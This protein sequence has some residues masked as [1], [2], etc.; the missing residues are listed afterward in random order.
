MAKSNKFGTFGG[1]FVPSILTIL[2]VI[3]Y[4]R[5]P[6]IVGEA[7]LWATIGIIVVAHI[8]SVTTGLSVSSIA[9][10]RKVEAGGTYY[11]ISRSLGL[12]IG[13]TLGL[14]LFVGL[15]F[16]VSLYLIGFSESFLGYWG[17]STDINNIRLTGTIVLLAVTTLTFISTSLA[18]KTQYFIMVA[19]LLSLIS[20]IFGNHEYTPETP[21]FSNSKSTVSLMVLFGIFFP[22]VTGF[23]AG[24]SMSGDLKDPK[25]SI[26][27]GSIMA[28]LIGFL[29]YIGLSFFLAYTV[30]SEALIGD[31][32]VLLNISWIPELVIAGI[33]GATLSS[34]LG[35]ILGAPRIL[36]ATA[37]DR[38]S[39]K[40]FAAGFG[41]TNEPRNALLLTFVIAELG[42]LIG[43]LDVIA[44]IVSIF[45][46]TTYGFL[47][48]SAAFERWTSADFRPEFKVSGWISLIGAIACIL[49]MIQLDFVAMVGAVVILGLLFLYLKRKELTLD[50][51]D[52]WSGVWAA[53][54]KTGLTNLMQDKIHN[55]N[56]RPNIIMF[57]GNPSNRKHM[58]EMGKIIAGKLGILSAF[59]LIKSDDKILAKTESNLAIDKDDSGYFQRKIFCRDVYEGMDQIARVYG[60]SGVEPNTVLMG[61][62]KQPT[63]KVKFLE[64]IGTLGQ[65]KFN[66]LFLKQP[67]ELGNYGNQ[68][69]DIWWSG[70]GRNL[71]LAVNLV[72]QIT[73]SPI[74]QKTKIRLLII[75][76]KNSEIE[77]IYKA[78]NVILA[79]YRLDAEIRIVNNE[80]DPLK[81][82]EIIH[83]ESKETDL[84]I[85][86]LP[87]KRFKMLDKYY[88]HVNEILDGIGTTL[89]I[90]ASED[91]EE[92]EVIAQT[93][94]KG[95]SQSDM[96]MSIT[97]PELPVSK[98]EEIN[99]DIEKVDHN[100]QKVLAL[101][102]KK[103]FQK[104]IED[105]IDTLDELAEQLKT[106]KNDLGK[107]KNTPE[108]YKRKKA[109]DRLKN[110][111]FFKI[112]YLLNED[113]K[114]KRIPLQTQKIADGLSWYLMKIQDDFTKYPR[115]LK[116]SYE[117]EQFK[118]N[119]SDGFGLR[120][121]KRTKRFKHFLVGQPITQKVEYR[122]IARYYQLNN[123]IAFLNQYL[124]QFLEERLSVFK[125][126]RNI[127][128]GIS[129]QLE[130]IDR[131]IWM[132]QTDWELTMFD[133]LT[134]LLDEHIT[135]SKKMAFIYKGRLSVEFRKNVRLMST[136]MEQIDVA[137]LIRKKSRKKKYYNEL[138]ETIN[139]FSSDYEVRIKTMLNMATLE[140]AINSTKNRLETIHES[141]KQVIKQTLKTNFFRDL[142]AIIKTIGTK[143]D[144]SEKL[145]LEVDFEAV[146]QESFDD[147]QEQMTQITDEM[148]ESAEVYSI[149][150]DNKQSEVEILSIPVSRMAKYYV[151]TQYTSPG[152]EAFE[153]L[154]DGLKRSIYTCQDD[155][156]LAQ[157]NFENLKQENSELTKDEITKDCVTKLQKER[158]Q[159]EKYIEIYEKQIGDQFDK[160]FE[161]L[162]IMRI[163]ESTNE[164][165]TSL[166]T[167]QSK[168]VISGIGNLYERLDLI[169][170][171]LVSWLF[172]S[173]SEGILLAKSLNK[174]EGPLS[175]NSM[176]L[177]LSDQVSPKKNVL[178][179]LPQYYVTLFNGRSSIGK[180]FWIKR[181]H[182]ELMFKK[183]YKRHQE[184]YAGGV[185]ILGE[186]NSGKTAF[187]KYITQENAKNITVYSVF[188]PMM[189]TKS[190][191]GFNQA[192]SKATK[193]KGDSSQ[194]L[195]RLSSGSIVVINDLELFWER[196]TDGLTVIHELEN[197]MD[198]FSHKIL[199]VV[200]LN[201]YAYQL[202][203]EMTSLGDHFIEVIN[204][205]P[206]DAEELKDLV[207]RR[208]QSSRIPFGYGKNYELLNPVRIASLFNAYFN[209]SEGNPGTALNG[210]L[211]HI[212]SASS[213]GLDIKKPEKPSLTVFK[214]L[215]EDWIMLLV[216][217]VLHKRL[218]NER[219]VTIT[220][221]S[222]QEVETL[223]L[224]MLRAGII[225]E[226]AAGVYH[227][228]PFILPFLITSLKERE[229]LI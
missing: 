210:W 70:T 64:L 157:Y 163:E 150:Q 42:I 119:K 68:T 96:S 125:K 224:A 79:N 91:F 176:L 8:I 135:E 31:S 18:I 137:N 120:L 177:D 74:W 121:H 214:N 103:T 93:K 208:H 77:S 212:K 47:N 118:I 126:L 2:G 181:P 136:D 130:I 185:L 12:P 82:S 172:Y 152:E 113:L 28:I 73:N 180:D 153:S 112:N 203:N 204:M 107:I 106:I 48:I 206:F 81:E 196:S 164:F 109:I 9:T 43:E 53:L 30:K 194:I 102:F 34:A 117:K 219:I 46:I 98:H 94:T 127:T 80:I 216:Q 217:F 124:E 175:S 215:N 166:R 7:G 189:G 158:A 101:F 71:S 44:R 115:K 223:V 90:N 225:I 131:K 27:G 22:A 99:Q 146:L 229:V 35:S 24:V 6:M 86:G 60:F 63:N 151:E 83:S 108:S 76:P 19:I 133:E 111:V 200:N 13:G 143:N 39:P 129:N 16:S 173:R 183:A 139:N 167:Y 160:I 3:M 187:A 211:A 56:W 193:V 29:V 54:V 190:L 159:V 17:F 32:Q 142:D 72:R 227:V 222:Y 21:I 89:V 205:M 147:H 58:V 145:K 226:K 59:E 171:K 75:N 33:W 10:D 162:H 134:I 95:S 182:E 221:R 201:P 191:D 97:L 85:L 184:G 1:V 5:L 40:F 50:T 141:H 37:A 57:S 122:E 45:F 188:P 174:E 140:L 55:R 114:D 213:E 199:F 65:S 220:N 38:I 192:M 178:I 84:I 41:P 23:E 15:S 161:P 14:A 186:R 88:D 78:S 52:A 198:S 202:I 69:V 148:P 66:T 104:V 132:D 92:H 26:P 228:S 168:Q 165:S 100:G 36:Q 179:S 116:I 209:Y 218:T 169:S 128:A 156:N 49:V 61:W 154:I 67:T 197:M 62:S 20:I 207:L 25:K 155:I 149:H 105:H 11:M 144:K 51:G 4:L 123:R 195:S 170:Q 138:I 87:D 110:E